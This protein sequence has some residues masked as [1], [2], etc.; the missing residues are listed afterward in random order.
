MKTLN[1]TFQKRLAHVG[2]F[3]AVGDQPGMF[4]ATVMRYDTV[5]AYDTV[6]APGCFND[7]MRQ[8]MPRIVWGHDWTDPIGRWLEFEDVKDELG[9]RLDLTGQLDN[10]DAVPRARQAYA[11]LS[12]GTIDQFSVGFYPEDAEMALIDGEECLRFTR[13]RLDEVSLVLVGAVPNTALLALRGRT[14]ITRGDTDI[15]KDVAATIIL[16]LYAGKLDLADALQAVKQ[17]QLVPE[18]SESEAEAEQP[19]AEAE[20]PEAEAEQPEAEAE[21]PEATSIELDWSEFSDVDAI[22]SEV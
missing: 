20:Q 19:E 6:F 1:R 3:R 15:P 13:A 8:R 11:Q 16:D 2:N 22:L 5:D 14:P 17:A 4:K 9:W 21:Q 12:S 10:F 7:S 18:Q